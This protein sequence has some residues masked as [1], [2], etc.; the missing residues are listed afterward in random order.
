MAGTKIN[1]ATLRSSLK[2]TEN[3]PIVDGNL[4]IGR[5]TLNN[6]K[7]FVAPDLST[8]ATKAELNMKLNTS[9]YNSDKAT[10]ATKTELSGKIS[11]T[12]VTQI[13]SV[14]E[15]PQSP[16]DGVLYIITTAEVTL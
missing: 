15:L 5:T 9:T 12:G 13:Q 4:P 8:Y 11:G 2:G 14:N 16:T 1:E 10:F 3:V 6:I 7:T